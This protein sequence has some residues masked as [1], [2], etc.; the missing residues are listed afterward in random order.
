MKHCAVVFILMVAWNSSP[1]EVKFI[2]GSYGDAT[3]KA[4]AEHKGVLIDFMTDWCRWC[5]TLDVRT[6]P[7]RAVSEF[8]NENFV[9]VKIDAEKGEGIDI[10]KKFGVRA[11]PTILL[12]KS[13]GEEIDRLVGYDPPEQFLTKVSNYAKGINTFGALKAKVDQQPADP[14]LRYQMARKYADRSEMGG[15]AEQF[16]KLVELDP[17]N[18]LGH[19]EEARFTI[20]MLGF[21]SSKDPSKLEEYLTTYPE[22]PLRRDALYT[23]WRTFTKEKDG[24]RARKYFETYLRK[25]PRDAGMMNNYAWGC[26]EAGINLDHAADVAQQAVALAAQRGERAMY[27]DTYAHVEFMRGNVDVAIAREQEALVL[28]ND[29]SPKER[30][31]YEEALA[32]FK[33]GMTNSQ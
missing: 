12:V 14:S 26:A 31:S 15:A 23:L 4:K 32:R 7:D 19:N 27:L 5:D 9:S 22:S 24:A 17:S 1:A 3:T 29:A 18:S 21:R 10:A 8:V 11:Y 16:Q 30:K 20:A 25:S 6:Y 33:S 28:L 13:D 2:K